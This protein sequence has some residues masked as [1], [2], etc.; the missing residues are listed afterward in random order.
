MSKDCL[1]LHLGTSESKGQ[2]PNKKVSTHNGRLG[3]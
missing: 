3:H 1:G 2:K